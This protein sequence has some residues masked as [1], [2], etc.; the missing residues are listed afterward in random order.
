[1]SY[2]A[3]PGISQTPR[4]KATKAQSPILLPFEQIRIKKA[5]SALDQ[6]YDYMGL[7]QN[8]ALDDETNF[9]EFGNSLI[10]FEENNMPERKNDSGDIHSPLL[11][12]I[13]EL[14]PLM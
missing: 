13:K 5:I 4:L 6:E 1:M 14:N 12:G 8:K 9:F 10:P 7:S 2:Q 3:F 11:G